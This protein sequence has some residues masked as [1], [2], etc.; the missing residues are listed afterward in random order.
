MGVPSL[1]LDLLSTGLRS[2]VHDGFGR[3]A[4]ISGA[5]SITCAIGATAATARHCT[6]SSAWSLPVSLIPWS[7]LMMSRGEAPI[8]VT[9]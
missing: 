3:V 9:T 8:A 2:P 5:A 7:A 4:A 1:S 6:I